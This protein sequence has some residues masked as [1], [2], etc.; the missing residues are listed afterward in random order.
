MHVPFR[1]RTSRGITGRGRD[2]NEDS[3]GSGRATV[4]STLVSSA[5]NFAALWGVARF[6]TSSEMGRFAAWV[7]VTYFF[8]AVQR[9]AFGE[10]LLTRGVILQKDLIIRGALYGQVVLCALAGVA[11]V[12][13]SAPTLSWGSLIV[14][15]AS[16]SIVLEDSLRYIAFAQRR[17]IYALT[18]DLVALVVAVAGGIIL[19]ATGHATMTSVVV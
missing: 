19:A 2:A 18:A 17:P 8:V 14:G 15:L 13:M 12:G 9:S 16:T 11:S 10:P 6:T 5:F 7:A 3:R 4:L 1:R